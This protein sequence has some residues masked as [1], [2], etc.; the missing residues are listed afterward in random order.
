[1]G[2]FGIVLS[3]SRLVIL[4]GS[5]VSVGALLA[6][7]RWTRQGQ[8][9]RAVAQD[10]VAAALQGVNV[11]RI[12]SSGFAIGSAL[13][14]VGAALILP[15]SFVAPSVGSSMALTAF[16]VVILG[17]LGSVVGALAGGLT[18]GFVQ[19]FGFLLFGVGSTLLGFLTI[20]V[21][22][23]LRPQGLLGHE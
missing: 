21:I 12:Y 11:D 15:I 16:V 2:I 3:G 10:P 6:F 18:L 14:A 7:L 9:M 17:G 19:T 22:L 23:L 4:I 13:A 8:A 5:L 1:M 20:M